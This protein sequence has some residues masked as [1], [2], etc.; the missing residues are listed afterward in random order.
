MLQRRDSAPLAAVS[1]GLALRHSDSIPLSNIRPPATPHRASRLHGDV[2][3]EKP[4][5]EY[6]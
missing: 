3:E 5:S 1:L 2:P 4:M 6:D